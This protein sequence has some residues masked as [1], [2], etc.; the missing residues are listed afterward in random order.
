METQQRHQ[1]GEPL[2]SRIRFPHLARHY[3]CLRMRVG[4]QRLLVRGVLVS[5]EK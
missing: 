4:Q 2:I 5:Y 3:I 1:G